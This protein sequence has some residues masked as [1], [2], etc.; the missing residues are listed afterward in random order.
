MCFVIGAHGHEQCVGD[1]GDHRVLGKVLI[2]TPGGRGFG[3]SDTY[4]AIPY[5]ESTGFLQGFPCVLIPTYMLWQ[6]TGFEG[7]NF[8]EIHAFCAGN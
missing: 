2:K 8:I 3:F 1:K 5:R 7:S 4:T 6:C